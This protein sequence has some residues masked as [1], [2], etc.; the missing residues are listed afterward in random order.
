MRTGVTAIIPHPRNLIESPIEAS[1]DVF[2][3]V[4][5]STGL[6]N[7]QEVGLLETPIVLTNT[8]S[9]G[10]AYEALTGWCVRKYLPNPGDRGWIAP[11]V[12]ETCDAHVND[13]FGF[14]VRPE[15][16][17][18][19]LDYAAVGPVAEGA[20]GCRHRHPDL[21][22]Q[23]RDRDIQPRAGL[24]WREIHSRRAGAE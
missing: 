13:I 15:H 19:A 22:V 2:N 21:R 11:V 5:T 7:L 14:H 17:L 20:R 24:R 8:M 12:G 4:G 16:V 3:G 23:G 1:V 9:V 6:H 18:E 10:T